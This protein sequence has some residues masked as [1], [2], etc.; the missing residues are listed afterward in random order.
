[1]SAVDITGIAGT[2]ID[3][4]IVGSTFSIGWIIDS[5]TLSLACLAPEQEWSLLCCSCV[6]A[7]ELLYTIC[8]MTKPPKP[9][10]IMSD[11]NRGFFEQLFS[12]SAVGGYR[13]AYVVVLRVGLPQPHNFLPRACSTTTTVRKIRC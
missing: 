3:P 10:D 7:I 5:D 8:G 12:F 4:H 2:T 6:G 9:V 11:R 1:M 13:C